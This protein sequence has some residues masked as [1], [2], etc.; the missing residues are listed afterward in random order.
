MATFEDLG[1]TEVEVASVPAVQISGQCGTDPSEIAAALG[2]AFCNLQ[3]YV[4]ENSLT[5]VGPPRTIYTGYGPEGMTFVVAFPIA[6]P[7]EVPDDS[8]SG[9]IGTLEGGK[10]MRFTHKGPYPKLMETYGQITEFLKGKG[11]ME[12]E[13][14]WAR[15]MPMWEEYLNDPQTTP[16]AELLTYIY[17]PVS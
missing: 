8:E 16:E 12:T 11:L 7:D 2:P 1:F 4:N 10:A 3:G 14:D 5:P 15:Y 13:A 17:L 9:A 6:A